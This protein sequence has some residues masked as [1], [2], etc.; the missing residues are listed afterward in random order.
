[1]N[2]LITGARAPIAADLVLCLARAGHKVWVGDSFAYPLGAA[3]PHIQSY[4]RLSSPRLQFRQFVADLI[5]V[6][7]DQAIDV[8]IPTSEEVFWLA[9]AVPFLPKS[10][11]VR[12]SSLP[13]LESLHHKAKFSKLAASLGFGVTENYEITQAS[14]IA[15]L[16]SELPRLVLKPVYSRFA[17]RTLLSPTAGE[18]ARLRFSPSN[19]WLAQTRVSGRELCSYNVAH[20]GRLLLHVAYEPKYRI[21][22]GASV[23]FSPVLSEKLRLLSERF[24]SET[25]FTGQISF[26][27]METERGLVALECNPRGTSG[28]HLAVQRPMLMAE[29]LL[30]R[31]LEAASFLA[32]PRMLLLPL[33]LNHPGLL[34]SGQ[35]RQTLRTAK[36]AMASAG[37]PLRA[38]AKALL[39]LGW[40]AI[41]NGMSMPM[42]STADIEWNGESIGA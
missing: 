29:A 22:V 41:R 36:D 6:C 24:I 5:R 28:I 33:L 10:V 32:E 8:I 27:V 4:L 12:S 25:G 16:K 15:R 38:Q 2:V 31:G 9:G 13:T 39:E 18:V 26:D 37:I 19:A 1:M 23:Y 3:S 11:D 7:T 17:T 40:V 42:A 30:G 35:C 14:H 20:A 34:F 21:G